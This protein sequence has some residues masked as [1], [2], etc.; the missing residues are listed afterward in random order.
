M[1][2]IYSLKLIRIERIVINIISF[3]LN[4]NLQFL[5]LFHSFFNCLELNHMNFI[6][7]DIINNKEKLFINSY[8][9]RISNICDI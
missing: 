5:L 1:F 2:N 4:L 3:C 6:I 8:Q 9:M 7:S